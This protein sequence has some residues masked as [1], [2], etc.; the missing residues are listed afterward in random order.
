MILLENSQSI[1]LHGAYNRRVLSRVFM[2]FEKYIAMRERTAVVGSASLP[3]TRRRPAYVPVT[4]D[5]R[6]RPSH[7]RALFAIADLLLKNH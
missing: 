3:T 1:I 6:G 4:V 2:M 5:G 7:H